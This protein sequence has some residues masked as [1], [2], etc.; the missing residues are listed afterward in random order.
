MPTF[1]EDADAFRNGP[2]GFKMKYNK[3]TFPFKGD[4]RA[5]SSAFQK[6]AGGWRPHHTAEMEVS[7]IERKQERLDKRASKGKDVS[8]AQE[9]LDKRSE[10]VYDREIARAERK[11]RKAAKKLEK[12]KGKQA[13]RKQYKAGKIREAV[14]PLKASEYPG[15]I[16]PQTYGT[17]P[18]PAKKLGSM[19]GSPSGYIDPDEKKSS[20]KKKKKTSP[21]ETV[22]KLQAKKANGTITPPEL[23]K[24][25]KLMKEMDQF[26]KDQSAPSYRGNY[27]EID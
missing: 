7:S 13:A 15:G 11:E 17:V 16:M 3:S 9:R 5:E 27:D 21:H 24:L 2:S 18:S 14:S 8:G 22:K 1:K 6:K 12:G 25:N 26:Y 19:Y 10:R 20:F 4:G 23:K